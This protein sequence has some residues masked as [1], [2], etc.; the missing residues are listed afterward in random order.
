MIIDNFAVIIIMHI[1]IIINF[2]IVIIFK[3]CAR[4][5]MHC[6]CVCVCSVCPHILT[7][8]TGLHA[9]HSICWDENRGCTTGDVLP[10]EY[11]DGGEACNCIH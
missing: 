3:L 7:L 1:I 9:P 8:H 4:E 10:Q 5:L 6:V 11:H 2:G